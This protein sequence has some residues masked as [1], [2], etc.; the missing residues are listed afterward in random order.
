M[1]RMAAE[2]A[3][4]IEAGADGPGPAEALIESRFPYRILSRV[5]SADRRAKDPAY[6]AHRWWARRPPSIVRAILLGL[7]PTANEE[8]L[9]KMFA[10]ADAMPLQGHNVLDPFVGGGSTLVEAQ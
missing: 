2:N 3:L 8:A 4:P 5:A 7:G 9:W 1:G 10:A 6:L